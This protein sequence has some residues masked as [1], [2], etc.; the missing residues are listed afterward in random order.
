MS[1][2]SFEDNYLHNADGIYV[3]IV[4]GADDL[5]LATRGDK[6]FTVPA[7]CRRCWDEADGDEKSGG[8][9]PAP[10]MASPY[11]QTAT[12]REILQRC[13]VDPGNSEGMPMPGSGGLTPPGLAPLPPPAPRAPVLAPPGPPLLLP[14]PSFPQA[15]L[16]GA[17]IPPPPPGPPPPEDSIDTYRRC[18]H[19]AI[20]LGGLLRRTRGSLREALPMWIWQ[21]SAQNRKDLSHHGGVSL[22]ALPWRQRGEWATFAFDGIHEGTFDP[23]NWSYHEA[24][25][26]IV[27]PPEPTELKY[28]SI[29]LRGDLLEDLLG[30]ELLLRREEGPRDFFASG[31]DPPSEEALLL[32]S[33][34]VTVEQAVVE[35]LLRRGL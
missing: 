26:L 30:A 22:A 18:V 6:D 2:G 33:A 20:R 32:R 5:E 3:C 14:P 29:G 10:D 17:G 19:T 4:C 1:F 34:R 15:L 24:M 7:H 12:L 9:P 13:P 35:T 21:E 23:G 27:G 11:G 16:R 28:L 8:P 25:P 31:L